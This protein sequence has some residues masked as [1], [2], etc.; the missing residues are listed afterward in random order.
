MDSSRQEIKIKNEVKNK[1]KLTNTCVCS[2]EKNNENAN[3]KLL[4]NF[5]KIT[6]S[7]DNKKE[8]KTIERIKEKIIR[9]CKIDDINNIKNSS[10]SE[11]NIEE[12]NILK[13]LNKNCS[14]Q[15]SNEIN[16]EKKCSKLM[17]QYIT[18]VVS[19]PS[20]EKI[21]Y[22]IHK[23]N[24]KKMNKLNDIENIS[25]SSYKKYS[26]EQINENKKE[27]SEKSTIR[28]NETDR[29]NGKNIKDCNKLCKEVNDNNHSVIDINPCNYD[30]KKKKNEEN[31]NMDD[32]SYV[33]IKEMGNVKSNYSFQ[34]IIEYNDEQLKKIFFKN[35]EDDTNSKGQHNS[36]KYC[37]KYL[38]TFYNMENEDLYNNSKSNNLINNNINIDINIDMNS[39]N[40]N[41]CN[42]Y[43]RNSINI[44]QVDDSIPPSEHNTLSYD[45]ERK[46]NDF[47]EDDSENNNILK[48]KSFDEKE[49]VQINESPN[50]WDSLKNNLR[51][52]FLMKTED[53]NYIKKE[54]KVKKVNDDA[55]KKDKDSENVLSGIEKDNKMICETKIIDNNKIKKK[56][57]DNNN[58]NNIKNIIDNNN[59]NCVDVSRPSR[60]NGSFPFPADIYV[61]CL[62][63]LK[64]ENI[65]KCELLNKMSCHVINNS[66][67]VFTYIRKLN[68]DEK[69]S[70]LPI[71]KRQFYLH[72]MRNIRHLNTSEKIYVENGMYIHEVA[73]IIYQNLSSLKTIELLSPEYF[74]NDNTPRHEPF[75]LYPS[76]FERLEKLTIIGCQTLEWLHIFRNCSFPL[77]KK[78]EVCYYPLHHDHWYWNFVFDF[79]QLGLQG[80]YKILY[81]MENLQKLIIGFDV[82]FD[83]LEGQ[84]YNP[85]ESHRNEL[86]EYRIINNNR[87]E[88][89]NNISSLSIP[90]AN[91]YPTRTFKSYRG[92]LCEEDFS[93]IFTIA[94]YMSG[95]CGKL[96]RI[97][98]KYRDSNEYYE[99]EIGKDEVV[100]ELISEASNTAST[101]YNYVLNWFRSPDEI[102]P[103]AS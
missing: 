79:T 50:F 90:P 67:G 72:Q 53:D 27:D 17:N 8:E 85:L 95:K 101:Y 78:F 40:I 33:H 3:I 35:K 82:W 19:M 94:Y 34:K 37:D 25:S 45:E 61:R 83:N 55:N 31:N 24:N 58:N 75:S 102:V 22:Y 91:G 32:N 9:K 7:N 54:D 39:S 88:R 29:L 66:M 84:I 76:V 65:L 87:N 16:K 60:D 18:P 89:Y 80:L 12:N 73:A 86:Q 62:N 44:N 30:I 42:S 98:I 23:E 77:L 51:N 64:L 63:F 36:A 96:T 49:W 92:K 43:K 59:N 13:Y 10:S 52:V 26:N 11:N 68:L 103:R 74:M 56:N 48:K 46:N 21:N 57:V 14:K 28:C 69:W 2:F 97:M 47:N 71:Y 5:H 1:K 93:D 38:E 81:T 4:G 6:S 15:K 100:N 41:N 70:I 20:N 99:D